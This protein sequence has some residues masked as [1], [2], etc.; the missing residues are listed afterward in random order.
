MTTS[1]EVFLMPDAEGMP[2]EGEWLEGLTED[3]MIAGQEEAMALQDPTY[4][5]ADLSAAIGR[6]RIDPTEWGSTWWNA[7]LD[8]LAAILDYA[9]RLAATD[10]R[11]NPPV[12]HG[13]A[14]TL[15]GMVADA[16]TRMGALP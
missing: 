11:G 9:A 14:V 16:L 10:Y 8:T 13:V 2:T 1:T 6:A 15:R 12:E 5:H 4:T 3:A 7:H